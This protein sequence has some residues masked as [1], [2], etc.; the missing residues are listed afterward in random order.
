MLYK[1]MPVDLIGGRSM[2]INGVIFSSIN[3]SQSEIHNKKILEVGALDV[4]GSLRPLIISHK[5]KI[6]IGVDIE[7]GRGVDEICKVENLLSKYGK[8]SFDMVIA[9]ELIEHVKDWQEAIHNIKNVCKNNGVI[10]ITTRSPGFPYHGFPNDYWRYEG[11]DMKNIFS[12]CKVQKIEKDSR[13]VFVKVKKPIKFIENDLINYKLYSIVVDKK[14]SK[15]DDKDLQ[16]FMF[17]WM[18]F[19]LKFKDFFYRSL[20][21]LSSKIKF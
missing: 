5:P 19:K 6:Y 4:N 17:K 18:I 8:E 12:D 3:L 7:K 14:V 11:Y 1:N 10:L 2:N 9:T 13:G 15:I 16:L 20:K 21:Y